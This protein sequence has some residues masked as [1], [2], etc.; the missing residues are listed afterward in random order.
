METNRST[1]T[2]APSNQESIA[3]ASH[4]Y[5]NIA[6]QQQRSPRYSPICCQAPRQVRPFCAAAS[7]AVAASA[8]LAVIAH[9]CRRVLGAVEAAAIKAAGEADQGINVVLQ[10][11]K[12]FSPLGGSTGRTT[13]MF[14]SSLDLKFA[15]NVFS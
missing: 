15:G 5:S 11:V 2:T 12:L 10:R 7:A 14:C 8:A 9:V 13:S 1:S 4:G 3:T 6:S